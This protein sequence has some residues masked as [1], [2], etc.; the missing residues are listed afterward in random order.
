MDNFTPILDAVAGKSVVNVVV[1]QFIR[2]EQSGSIVVVATAPG[3]MPVK[4]RP[5]SDYRPE[6]L[7][8]VRVMFVDGVAFYAGAAQS[9]PGKGVV[10]TV[11]GGLATVVTDIGTISCSYS[12]APSSGNA[13][14]LAWNDGPHIMGPVASYPIQSDVPADPIYQPKPRTYIFKANA[15]G[16]V[17]YPYD[18]GTDTTSFPGTWYPGGF[19][20]AFFPPGTTS[21]SYWFYGSKIKDT[22]PAGAT[23][24]SA[25]MFFPEGTTIP[26]VFLTSAK[27]IAEAIAALPT[28]SSGYFPSG[29]IIAPD[30]SGGIWVNLGTAFGAAVAANEVSMGPSSGGSPSSKMPGI[31]SLGTGKGD[32][33]SGAIRITV[34]F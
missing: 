11:G 26:A 15:S 29:N 22:I 10:A 3:Q 32:S 25:E 7:E 14:K 27:S 4:C 6:P 24:V 34:T 28:T 16:T 30:G 20:A 31:D 18:S 2:M 5:M 23:F 1:G 9:K 13:V 21:R 17:R 8:L 19:S 12:T 33:L